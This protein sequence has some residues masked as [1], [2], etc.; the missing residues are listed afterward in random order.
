MDIMTGEKVAEG[1]EG[2]SCLCTCTCTCYVNP[3]MWTVF[4]GNALTECDTRL[5]SLLIGG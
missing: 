4:E 2:C 5:Y 1:P 3:D